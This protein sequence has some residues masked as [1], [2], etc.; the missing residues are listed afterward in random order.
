MSKNVPEEIKS[1]EFL[2]KVI[3]A[4]RE[5]MTK[6]Q[7][8]KFL[9]YKKAAESIGISY[10]TLLTFMQQSKKMSRTTT[11]KIVRWLEEESK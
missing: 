2:E 3:M 11:L 4:V 1:P 7:D 6:M 8:K 10:M 5:R 9:T